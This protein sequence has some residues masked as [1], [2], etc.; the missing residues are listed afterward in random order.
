MPIVVAAEMVCLCGGTAANHR[1]GFETLS[2]ADVRGFRR[3]HGIIVAI[4]KR[5][6]R[7]ALFF[8]PCEGRR[9]LPGRSWCRSGGSGCVVEPIGPECRDF[10]AIRVA[11]HHKT[12]L[13]V[14]PAGRADSARRP[15]PPC[16]A[17]PDADP[18]LLAQGQAGAALPEL[19]ARPVQ[20]LPGSAGL[21]EAGDGSGGRGRPRRRHDGHQPVRLLRRGDAESYP[22]DYEPTLARELV[23]YLETEPAG[24]RLAVRG[25]CARTDAETVDYIVDINRPAEPGVGT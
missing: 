1:R 20:Q 16:A 4:R 13:P 12:R 19:A 21:P 2:C 24:P 5:R 14:R 25:V 18:E 3:E 7:P 22:F 23:P 17:L 6:G 10:M 15:A 11:L 8:D 9:E